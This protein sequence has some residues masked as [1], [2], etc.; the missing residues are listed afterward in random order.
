M[1]AS[2]NKPRGCLGDAAARPTAA[3]AYVVGWVCCHGL[4]RLGVDGQLRIPGDQGGQVRLCPACGIQGGPQHRC[5]GEAHPN[6]LTVA[7]TSDASGATCVVTRDKDRVKVRRPRRDVREPATCE[8]PILP[9][10]G[11]AG[12]TP[13]PQRWTSS[14]SARSP[15]GPRA[16]WASLRAPAARCA[17]LSFGRGISLRLRTQP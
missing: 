13:S 16:C 8:S 14:Q 15:A 6:R 17:V 2:G 12:R 3:S 7:V 5:R 4:S 11:P 10:R 1:C 9:E